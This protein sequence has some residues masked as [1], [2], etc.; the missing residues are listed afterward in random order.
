[1]A[2]LNG[3]PDNREPVS[4]LA[5]NACAA[6][7]IPRAA[8]GEEK[9]GRIRGGVGMIP[10]RRCLEPVMITPQLLDDLCPNVPDVHQTRAARLVEAATRLAD[11]LD[12]DRAI[13]RTA[14]T[15]L[16]TGVM[17]GSD[18]DG[19]WTMRDAYDACE[20]AQLL[21][22]RRTGLASAGTDPA[23]LGARINLAVRLLALLPTQTVRSEVQIARQQFSTPLPITM[24]TAA[25]AQPRAGETCLEPSAG[26]GLLAVHLAEAGA[27]LLLNEIDPDRA[28]LLRELFPTAIVSCD[29]AVLLP[30][31]LTAKPNLILMNP[32]FSRSAGIG[33]DAHAGARHLLAALKLLAPDGRCVAVMPQWFSADGSGRAGRAAVE[34]MLP[35]VF[36]L[37][38]DGSFYHAHGT[39]IRVRL[40]VFDKGNMQPT[41]DRT[42]TSYMDAAAALT[43]CPVRTAAPA[44]R[45]SPARLLSVPPRQPTSAPLR[46]GLLSSQRPRPAAPRPPQLAMTTGNPTP[47]AYTALAEPVPAEAASGLYVPHRVA[48]IGFDSAAPHPT[49]LVE[50]LAMAAIVPPEPSYRPLLPAFALKGLSSA[51]LE[52]I[53]YAGQ[54]FERDL[55]G[56]YRPANNDLTLEEHAEGLA[57]RAGFFLGDGTGAGKGRQVA[58]IL[59][60]NWCRGRRR[61]LWVSKTA[62]LIEDARRDWAALGGIGLDIQAISN[63][64]LDVPITISTGILFTTYATLRSERADKG[65]RIDQILAWLGGSGEGAFDGTIVFDESH[66]LANAAG[67]ET[68]R[69]LVKGSEQGIAGVRLQHRLPRARVLYVSATGATEVANLAYAT[70]LGLWGTGTAFGQ[71]EAF[72][73]AMREGGIA[74]MELVARDLKAL[75]YYTARALSYQGIEYDIL[76]H[77]LQPDQIAVYD[78]YCDAW[79]IIHQNLEAVLAATNVNDAV[80]GNTLNGQARGAA[81]SKFESAK[82]RFFAQVLTAMKLPSLIPAIDADLERG[83]SIVIQLV[84]TAEAMLDRR[85][86][87]LTP[88]ERADLDIDLSP[89]ELVI[90][91]LTNAFPVM[92]MEPYRDEE[93]QMRSRVAVDRSGNHVISA[94]AVAVRDGLVEE[95][96]ALPTVHAA[97][98]ALLRHYGPELVAEI[99]GRSRRLVPQRDGSQKLESRSARANLA[100]TQAFMDGAKRILIFSDAGG[101]GRSY[102]AD[103]A[104]RNQARRI[105]YLLEP[106]WRAD[107][108]IQGLGRSHRTHQASAPLFRPVTTDVKGEKRF[109]STIARRLDSLGALTRGQRQTGGQNLFNVADN[110]ESA[111]AREALLNWYRLLHAGKLD[112]ID[113]ESFQRRSGLNLCDKDS[114][115]LKE[116]LPPIQRWLNRLLAFPIALQNGIFEEYLALVEARAEALAKAGKLDS[117]VETICAEKIVEIDCQLLRRDPAT[118]AETHLR[119]L[120]L[121]RRPRVFHWESLIERF[122]ANKRLTFVRNARSGHVAAAITDERSMS[123]SGDLIRVTRLFRVTRNETLVGTQLADTHWQPVP[124]AEAAEL[125][126][127][128][129]AQAMEAMDISTIRMITGL[130][131]PIWS[132]IPG[133]DIRVWRVAVD[134]GISHLGRLIEE[135]DLDQLGKRLGTE[136][137]VAADPATLVRAALGRRASPIPGTAL[138]LAPARVNGQVRLELKGYDPHRLGWYKSLGCFTEIIAYR[139]RLFIPTDRGEAI[140]RMLVPDSTSARGARS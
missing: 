44:S 137:S 72:M 99:T 71:R 82:Q 124:E 62:T 19:A 37:L 20:V 109:I 55:P 79:E 136:I 18:A 67:S 119:T 6:L 32:P 53:V 81:L 43:S 104:A 24:L 110:L 75:G 30:H 118:A 45:P 2:I 102:H 68:A 40:L 10:E 42:A 8:S 22:A 56:R 84:S 98:D 17:G 14:L 7:L 78:R 127:A 50:S 57:Y 59:M 96:C 13:S 70:R 52:T 85:I 58:G 94:E 65:S 93:G 107:A 46:P 97:L 103:L 105:H 61:H 133:E 95:L 9:R 114:G 138:E 4:V 16:M 132:K 108:A 120:E 66:A 86:A 34:E 112:A 48:R 28:A 135:A 129:E 54:S 123:E 115:A 74:A 11:E 134:G 39:S 83:Y 126:H 49:P 89:R 31:R 111:H 60:D 130:L 87:D 131:L 69:G 92:L 64:D 3:L 100:E 23:S 47:L 25:L 88:E 128:E 80:T 121:H 12:A 117:G 26:T 51:Q 29:N 73:Q 35:P 122:G 116:E 27:R 41:I 139:T 113:L 125:W 33:E 101:T 90:D 76:E 38:L 36:D 77:R 106:G 1:M 91:Y 63:F 5:S 15:D 140:V 21:M